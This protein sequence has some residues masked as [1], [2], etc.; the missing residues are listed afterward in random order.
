MSKYHSTLHLDLDDEPYKLV[1][2]HPAVL[3][4]ILDQY[5]RPRR[6][7]ENNDPR[8]RLIGSLLG[9]FGNDGVVHVTNCFPV[10]HKEEKPD[11]F[12]LNMDCLKRMLNLHS[13]VSP[14]QQLVGWYSTA[15][16]SASVLVH[17]F[18]AKEIN[19]SPVHLL[20]DLGSLDKGVL[21]INCYYTISVHFID[22][23]KPVPVNRKNPDDKKLQEHFRP[24]RYM[25]KSGHG[26]RTV[27]ERLIETKEMTLP[28]QLSNNLESLETALQSLLEMINVVSQ[29]VKDVTKG[30]KPGEVKIGHLIEDTLALLPIYDS[31]RFEKIFTKGLQDVLMI[32]YLA[33]LTRTHL[34]LAEQLRDQTN[35]TVSLDI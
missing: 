19:R 13:T 34:L 9:F 33:N 23:N 31:D 14:Q 3:F 12:A 20:L 28:P 24:I 25:I 10:P 29:Y 17:N 16:N 2:I 26:E 11:Q 35:A 30:T 4:S 21:S 27:I 32:V 18:Y 1:E 22:K 8:D 15:F 5:V 7:Q 6:E